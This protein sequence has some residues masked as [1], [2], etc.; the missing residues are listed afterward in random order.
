MI[1]NELYKLN[2]LSPDTLAS[3]KK[4]A[5]ADAT[6]AD[7]AGDYARGNKR[8]KGI[9]RATKKQFDQDAK[10]MAEGSLNEFAPGAGGDDEAGD[11]PYKYPKPKRY[12]RSADYFEQFEADHFDR[13]DFDDDT[14]VFKGY[15]GNKQI[16]YFK[17]DN[18]AR[19][20]SN[21]PGMGWYYEPE[22][23]GRSDNTNAAPAA[24]DSAERKQQELSMIR[25]F[26][27]SG[28]RPNPDSQ[29]GRL[30]KKHGMTEGGE[31]DRQWSNK[32]MERLRVATRDF[33]DIL[34]ADGPDAFK[35]Q[36]IKKRIQTKPMS[37]PKGVLPE[38]EGQVN[39]LSSDLLQKAAQVA[40]NK[41]DRAMDPKI[42]DA[43]GGGYMNPLAK[44]YDNMSDKF[45]N[46]AAK[47]GQKDAVKKIASPAAM[48]KIGM[49]EGSNNS[50]TII[51]EALI[52]EQL[53]NTAGRKL[54]EAQLTADQITQIF[55]QIQQDA[56]AAGGNRTLI[57][58]GKDA[59]EAVSAAWTAL[60]DKIYNSKPM[61]N[62]ASAYDTAA[63]KLKQATGGDAGAMKYIQKYRDFAT[64]HPMLQSAIYAALIAASGISG[65]GIAGAAALGLFK[66]F[67]QAIQ[68]KDIRS[69]M[70]S[71]VKTGAQAFAAGQIG[72]ALKGQPAGA[73]G[74]GGQVPPDMQ[75]AIAADQAKMEW[76]QNKYSP[77]DGFKY[78][79][80][81]D[82]LSVFDAAGNKV[83]SGDIPFQS[84]NAEQFA[85]LAQNGQ[86]V[87]TMVNQGAGVA[88]DVAAGVVD[89]AAAGVSNAGAVYRA[90]QD[91]GIGAAKQAIQSGQVGNYNG[92]L[93]LTDQI[94][95]DV[96]A[97]LSPQ[98]YKFVEAGVRSTL[99]A[100]LKAKTNESVNLS[101][102]Q[103]FFVIGK[104]VER[105]RKLDEGIMDTIKGAAGKAVGSVVNYAKTKGTNLTTKITADKLLQAWKK[106]GSPMDS[107]TVAK[108]I[109]DAGV[110][111]TSVQQ[112]YSTM[113]I[114]FDAAP[115]APAA[116]TSGPGD[117]TPLLSPAQLAAKRDPAAPAPAS[118]PGDPTPLLSPAQLAAKRDPAAPAA[119]TTAPG[120]SSTGGISQP[121]ATGVRH[122]ASAANPN[123]PAAPKAPA[124]P[125]TPGAGA[126]GQ[127]AG[128][129]GA[130]A[131]AAAP[132]G[133]FPGEDPQG[134]GYLGR[135]EVA[136]QQAARAAGAAKPAPAKTPNFS[137]PA[138][139]SGTNYTVKQPAKQPA[140]AEGWKDEADDF[141]EW[142][143][144][145]REKLS[146]SSNEQRL[147]LAKKLSQLEVKH[148]GSTINGG[149]DRATGKPT[150][151]LGLTDT[152]KQILK[153]FGSEAE[154]TRQAN[155]ALNPQDGPAGN[156]S[157]PFGS[158]D[159][160]GLEGAS[161]EVLRVMKK[162]VMLGADVAAAAR[163][164]YKKHGTLTDQ[165][166]PK[167]QMSLANNASAEWNKQHGMAEG[168]ERA[169][170]AKGRTQAQW[171]QLVKA[172][173]PDGKMIQAKMPD[174]PVQVTLPDG[175]KLG[176]K[177]VEQIDEIFNPSSA[178]AAFLRGV[179]SV[180][181]D[182]I[183][184]ALAG[185]GTAVAASALVGPL[186][187]GLMGTT[188][189]NALFQAMQNQQNRVPGMLQ[190]LIEKY[191]GSEAEQTEFSVLHAK[192]A[193]QGQSGFR[194]RGKQWP[195]TL[196][197][198]D[199]EAIIEKNDKFWLDAEKQ[200]EIDAEKTKD[201]MD[202][203]QGVAESAGDELQSMLKSAGVGRNR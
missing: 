29:I 176:W 102:S 80:S 73:D 182:L 46:R 58:K 183:P 79:G 93:E 138:G 181:G 123:Q 197:K 4:A 97:G 118:G 144:Y 133:K 27:K 34:S 20:G 59:A 195:V 150:A 55:Q 77:Y 198:N 100:G 54:M 16:A 6:A 194:W 44:H 127:M 151:G 81:G 200:K 175:R 104:I 7:A 173:F 37:G 172:K 141:S 3:Y 140:V 159:V 191:F 8:F 10:G 64:K 190:K 39:E 109:Q 92:V 53:W 103:I 61:S 89:K 157:M 65:V 47:V 84:L 112:V 14:G 126:F 114:P 2:E 188:A 139:Y 71:G 68:G 96:G 86:N 171:I 24:D 189:G 179:A 124:A 101:E 184:A 91:A 152:V 154:Y 32:D 186:A 49:T 95:A 136:R 57:G 120:A 15:W 94:M 162:A 85:G 160:A 110:P 170:D 45:S 13:E 17:F 168:M 41:S 5:G 167:I 11:D 40:K 174:G 60:K 30:M 196:R 165:D 142:S 82:S 169:V 23:S 121:T 161:P 192:N 25:A 35:Q 155:A 66:L 149:F 19:T 135:R 193:Y 125:A 148:F 38:A 67:D 62:F 117:P 185:V 180:A 56:T 63:E 137:G 99:M 1:L 83:F 69:A 177:K 116:P 130:P 87:A 164:F 51:A 106:A 119:P 143:D 201:D 42:H 50:R 33:D 52:T 129:L 131:A 98:S 128:Q 36:L 72:Q 178:L 21:N 111:A 163:N 43:L 199:A 26:L 70:W 132:A 108:V 75:N 18:P 28:N 145:V 203:E 76:F 78:Q 187:G 156:F 12:N 22:S 31:K 88:S 9:V 158:V 147:G 105:Q 202:K 146:K 134:A 115:A 74:L 90:A 153:S 166:L 113:K 107:A 122:T 48:R